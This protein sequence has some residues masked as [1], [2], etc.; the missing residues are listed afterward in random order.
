MI[1]EKVYDELYGTIEDLRRRVSAAQKSDV[2]IIPTLQA[3]NKLADFS[4]DGSG[5][6]IYAPEPSWEDLEDR[7]QIQDDDEAT[8]FVTGALPTGATVQSVLNSN[9][10]YDSGW[11]HDGNFYYRKVG[12]VVHVVTDS[13]PLSPTTTTTSVFTLPVGFR[14]SISYYTT[15]F[16]VHTEVCKWWLQLIQMVLYRFKA[17]QREI[18]AA[19]R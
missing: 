18:M 10:G 5:G 7:P 1:L 11:I 9:L 14:P 16:M 6:S 19:L 2:S 13:Y 15:G 3:G 8:E 17:Q 12:K 4:I